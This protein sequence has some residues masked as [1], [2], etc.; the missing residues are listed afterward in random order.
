MILQKQPEALWLIALLAGHMLLGLA[1]GLNMPL[2]EAPDEPGHY[3]FVRYIQA[4]RA[5]PVQT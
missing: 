2:F 4:C 1:Y 5:L 3:L